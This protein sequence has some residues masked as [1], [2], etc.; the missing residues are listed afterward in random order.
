MC[1]M[2]CSIAYYHSLTL[3]GPDANDFNPDRFI[4][5]HG[6]LLPALV[7]TKD[8]MLS[9]CSIVLMLTLLLQKARHFTLELYPS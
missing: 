1:V 2:F 8:G 7:D 4:D 5:E 3:Q 6:E 9:N